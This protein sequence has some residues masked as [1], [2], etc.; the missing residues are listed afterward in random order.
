M[1]LRH[2]YF[3]DRVLM[4]QIVPRQYRWR[5]DRK[6]KA[7]WLRLRFCP[8]VVAVAKWIVKEVV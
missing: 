4:A 8:L 6:P 2:W 1:S 3:R 5:P 7:H